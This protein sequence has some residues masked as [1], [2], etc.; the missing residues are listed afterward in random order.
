MNYFGSNLSYLRKMR[1]YTQENLSK[2]L[3]IQQQTLSHYEGEQREP[4]LEFLI[5]S[6]R[7]LEVSI[8][9]LLTKDL[10]PGGSAL[11]RNIR[12]LRKRENYTQGDM[13][14][15]I[16]VQSPAISKYESGVIRPTIEG[17]LNLSVFFGIST[18]DLLKKDLEKEGF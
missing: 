15:L 18:D 9:D 2:A 12:Y 14:Q 1:N 7:L 4:G 16:G 5:K 11:S 3:G 17:L 6:S 10:R 8:D 13:A